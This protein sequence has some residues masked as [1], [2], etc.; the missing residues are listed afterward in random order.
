MQPHAITM[1]AALGCPEQ[2]SSV[3]PLLVDQSSSAPPLPLLLS[4]PLSPWLR[5]PLVLLLLFLVSPLCLLGVAGSAFEVPPHCASFRPSDC[6]AAV[7]QHGVYEER[8][9]RIAKERA[10]V[11]ARLEA[12]S[13]AQPLSLAEG[14]ISEGCRSVSVPADVPVRLHMS[15]QIQGW[16]GHVLARSTPQLAACPVPCVVSS[17][18]ASSDVSFTLMDPADGLRCDQSSLV[19]S[20]ESFHG[21]NGHDVNAEVARQADYLM[22]Y[23]PRSEVWIN[24]MYALEEGEGACAKMVPRKRRS[25]SGNDGST[26]QDDTQLVPAC[27]YPE[28]GRPL[29]FEQPV[30]E[31]EAQLS[32]PG[33]AF[34]ALFVGNCRSAERK[35]YLEDLQAAI[36]QIGQDEQQQQQQPPLFESYS[37]CLRTPGADEETA[38]QR[39]HRLT[40]VSMKDGQPVSVSSVGRSRVKRLVTGLYPFAL[41][42]ENEVIPSYVTEKFFDAFVSG[43]LPV[44][45][46]APNSAKFAPAPH[47]FIN[48]LDYESPAHLAR[49]LHALR[50]NVTAYLEYFEWRRT[51][52]SPDSPPLLDSLRFGVGPSWPLFLDLSS[53]FD[54]TIYARDKVWWGGWLGRHI[55]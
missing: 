5:L 18:R 54:R 47:S 22:T 6:T 20:S 30:S 37:D 23:D 44:Y 55:C 51:S 52:W 35:Q 11:R 48:A 12:S 14:G 3:Q 28:A 33:L 32:D 39:A 21:H 9:Q 38:L 1:P 10:A 53:V 45:W 26:G 27:L 7:R 43:A 29:F 46:G 41:A 24:Y 19:V 36:Q 49:H 2:R 4:S 40:P 31:L 8:M 15:D 50:K 34:S 42:L 25:N 16:W 13:G 17:D